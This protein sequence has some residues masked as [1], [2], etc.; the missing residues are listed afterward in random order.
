MNLCFTP[1][2][3]NRMSLSDWW[4]PASIRGNRLVCT[5]AY[6]THAYTIG[7]VLTGYWIFIRLSPMCVRA[8]ME[9]GIGSRKDGMLLLL[10]LLLISF[11]CC[12]STVASVSGFLLLL[13]RLFNTVASLLLRVICPT[14]V[15]A[16]AAAALC[17][18]PSLRTITSSNRTRRC[19]W[20]CLQCCDRAHREPRRQASHQLCSKQRRR[21]AGDAAGYIAS[22]LHWRTRAMQGDRP[23]VSRLS[24]SLLAN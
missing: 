22:P 8:S 16:A 15:I 23:V 5:T 19:C 13:L 21:R 11:C 9:A 4:F 10:K 14:T 3:N 24:S 18:S 1:G 12:W 7:P 20:W 17:R 2:S 6:K